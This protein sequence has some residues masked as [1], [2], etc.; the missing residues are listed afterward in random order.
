MSE[1]WSGFEKILAD[2]Q[3]WLWAGVAIAVGIVLGLLVVGLIVLRRRRQT[4]N[5]WMD[6]EECIGL[7]GIVEV[8]FDQN[9]SGKVRLQLETMTL[10][11]F[12]YSNQPHQFVPGDEVVV[13]GIKGKKVWVIPSQEFHG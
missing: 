12:A 3:L 5:S 8:P 9:S 1:P 11:C 2:D 10:G 4:F 6:L 13:V 7:T